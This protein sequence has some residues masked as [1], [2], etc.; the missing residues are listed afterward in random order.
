[1]SSNNKSPHA[2]FSSLYLY[3]NVPFSRCG[4]IKC[5]WNPGSAFLW[6]YCLVQSHSWKVFQACFMNNANPRPT[7]RTFH[8]YAKDKPTM[9]SSSA[10]SVDIDAMAVAGTALAIPKFGPVQRKCDNLFFPWRWWSK[11][12]DIGSV[13]NIDHGGN[14]VDSSE[15]VGG[16]SA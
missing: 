13:G 11:T 6:L 16:F 5:A 7:C 2:E 15:V 1:M 10:E 3:L 8:S 12:F 9:L 4:W 14:E